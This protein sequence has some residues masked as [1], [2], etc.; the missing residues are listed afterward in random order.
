MD[1]MMTILRCFVPPICRYK[2]HR[3]SAYVCFYRGHVFGWHVQCVHFKTCGF[4]CPIKCWITNYSKL[5]YT[6]LICKLEHYYIYY[7]TD[8]CITD[9]M[10]SLYDFTQKNI[11]MLWIDG[12]LTLKQ[13]FWLGPHVWRAPLLSNVGGQN[14]T[15]KM[16]PGSPQIIIQ[17]FYLRCNILIWYHLMIEVQQM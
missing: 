15:Y 3:T 14:R 8:V 17:Y 12:H 1:T 10:E 5:G 13:I 7:M 2:W 16:L 4:F 9:I 6:S 11:N